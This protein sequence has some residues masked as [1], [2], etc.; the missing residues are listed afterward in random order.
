VDTQEAGSVVA[1]AHVFP[2]DSHPFPR[3]AVRRRW[4]EELDDPGTQVYVGV[5]DRGEVIGFAATRGNELLH[6]GSAVQTWGTGVAQHL[7]AALLDEFVRTTQPLGTT[8]LRLRVFE[9]NDRARRFYEKLGWVGSGERSRS[10]FA[11]YP[12]LVEYRRPT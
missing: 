7:H 11:P 12:Q 5:D 2:Q 6:F 4:A 9:A 3:S 1:L 10:T 8:F